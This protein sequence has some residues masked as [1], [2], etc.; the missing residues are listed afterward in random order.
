[1][2]IIICLIKLFSELSLET[3]SMYMTAS[4]DNVMDVLGNFVSILTISELDD[5]YF[6]VFNSIL[7]EEI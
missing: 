6:Q 7:K 5:L 2:P 3:V 4:Y 1:M